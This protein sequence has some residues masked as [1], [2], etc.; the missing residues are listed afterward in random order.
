ML[1]HT[2]LGTMK[3]PSFE[4]V[5]HEGGGGEGDSFFLASVVEPF[6]FDPAPSSQ[7]AGSSSSCKGH[8]TIFCC[9]KVVKQ[10]PSYFSGTYFIHR[11][12]PVPVLCITLP[13]LHGKGQINLL[14]D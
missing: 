1:I 4:E 13:V 7:D 3:F 11:K 10:F 8:H 6:H 14:Q 9:N 5:S 12:V 2:K